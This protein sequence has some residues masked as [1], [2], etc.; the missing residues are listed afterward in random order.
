MHLILA[1]DAIRPKFHTIPIKGQQY[2]RKMNS[3]TTG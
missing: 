1:E 2:E 3:I